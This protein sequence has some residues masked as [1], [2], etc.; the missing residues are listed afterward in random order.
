MA[1]SVLHISKYPARQGGMDEI[2][3]RHA[4]DP[5][6]N[7]R[8]LSLLAIPG[9]E[10]VTAES[11]DG[12][13]F[14]ALQAGIHVPMGFLARRARKAFERAAP[15]ISLYYNCWGADVLAGADASAL[16]IGYVHNHFPGFEAYVNYYASFLDGF[17]S[18]SPA[19][20]SHICRQVSVEVAQNSAAMPL[21]VDELFYEAGRARGTKSAGCVIGF[22]GRMTRAQKRVDRL[23]DL[24]AGLDAAG[25]DYRLELL[26]DGP[27]RAW[28]AERLGAHPRVSFLGWR[29][30]ASV[31][32]TFA[33]WKYVVFTSDYEGQSLALL[34]AI[35]AGC[36][37]V[38]P[39]FH[40]GGELPGTASQ[41][42]LY[43]VGDIK[44]AV[45]RLLGMEGASV[46]ELE[47]LRA[48]L[49][50]MIARHQ[51]GEYERAFEQWTEQVRPAGRAQAG[52]SWRRLVEPV[53]AYNRYYRRLTD[54]PR[55]RSVA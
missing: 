8:F 18:V 36:L 16:R 7:Q 13:K 42:C 21:P 32:K 31:A 10:H 15:A 44:S 55:P 40:V 54:G 26:G 38:Y 9:S 50:A 51:P 53:F 11:D 24:A 28:L 37:P 29:A 14:Q 45:A 25:V 5:S 35:A 19:L 27:D 17:L 39:D 33:A 52:P 46:K 49:G 12:M 48:E 41:W 1:L 2:L 20:H 4:K 3:R 6:G 34:E 30:P 23:P 47:P 22:C 43:P